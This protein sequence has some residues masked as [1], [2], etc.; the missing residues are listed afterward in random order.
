[1]V[2]YGVDYPGFDSMWQLASWLD[3]WSTLVLHGVKWSSANLLR[4]QVVMS[5]GMYH[6]NTAILCLKR[7]ASTAN[8]CTLVGEAAPAAEVADATTTVAEAAAEPGQTPLSAAAKAKARREAKAK[9]G[10]M[11]SLPLSSIVL[12]FL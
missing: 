1:M 8:E 2:G 11:F 12:L 7:D 10:F 9:A 4:L 3:L 5:S 6:L